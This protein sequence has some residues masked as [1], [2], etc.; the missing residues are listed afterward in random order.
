MDE[1]HEES[2]GPRGWLLPSRRSL[3]WLIY[4]SETQET[5]DRDDQQQ[6]NAKQNKAWDAK[7]NGGLLR[8]FPQRHFRPSGEMGWVETVQCGSHNGNLQV[9]WLL[10]TTTYSLDKGYS[11]RSLVT[12]PV[13][14]DCWHQYMNP[15]TSELEPHNVLYTVSEPVGENANKDNNDKQYINYITAPWMPDAVGGNVLEFLQ[16]RALL[17]SYPD[18]TAERLFLSQYASQFRLLEDRE[19]W[20]RGEDPDGSLVEDILPKR[21]RLVVFDSVTLPHE[22]T[23]VIKGSRSALAGWFHEE[24]QPLGG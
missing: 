2:K 6:E 18:H 4:L 23:A 17:E 16:Q 20:N 10:P 14:L 11:N 1:R 19:A 22:V 24:T 15:Y 21:G 8:T 7:Q 12:H 13:F 5:N 3:S 9:G